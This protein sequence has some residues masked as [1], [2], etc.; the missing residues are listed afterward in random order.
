MSEAPQRG[1]L[2]V[3]VGGT[4]TDLL[5]VDPDS[6][7]MRIAKVP[8]TPADQ[9]DGFMAGLAALGEATGGFETVVHGTT[10]GTNAVLERKGV[11]CAL[12]TTQ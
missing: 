4:F 1:R 8:S 7:T 9:S 2:G 3:D 6:A 12:I 11:R 5:L 10:V